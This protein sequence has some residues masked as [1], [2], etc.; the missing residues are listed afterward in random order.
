MSVPYR[1]AASIPARRAVRWASASPGTSPAGRLSFDIA[2]PSVPVWLP[3]SCNERP[4]GTES[5]PC[6]ARA[7]G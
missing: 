3:P 6:G 4:S 5:V 2:T 1:T 7:S